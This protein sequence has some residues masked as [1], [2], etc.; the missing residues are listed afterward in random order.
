MAEKKK[1]KKSNKKKEEVHGIYEIKKD[2]ET[3]IVETGGMVKEEI[4]KKGQ[5]EEQN[6]ALISILICIGF[7]LLMVAIY[8]F[9]IKSSN[10]FK[11][12]GVK[13]TVIKQ[14]Q[15][16]FYQT[17]FPVMYNGSKAVYNIYLRNDPRKLAKEVPVPETP[18][19]IDNTVINITQEFDCN[20]DQVIAIANIVNLYGALGK[21]IM[22]D[23]NASC[24]PFGR[25]MYIVIKPGNETRIDK[26]GPNCYNININKCEILQGT[27]MFI[28]KILVRINSDF[29]LI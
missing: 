16:T 9:A 8:F 22:R 28:T 1:V 12:D 23:E 13:F 29:Q 27:E 21:K 10:Q 2:G 18:I 7:L 17:S 20:G 4:I 26:V 3:E 5:K 24:D 14:R 19:S 6:K 15:L 11:Y 25:Y